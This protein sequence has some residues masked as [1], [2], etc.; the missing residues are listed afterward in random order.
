VRALVDAWVQAQNAGNFAAYSSLY[1]ERFTGIKRVGHRARRYDTR[2]QWLADRKKMFAQPMTV[3]ASLEGMRAN[4]GGMAVRVHQRFASGSFADAGYKVLELVEQ[5]DGALRIT[6][7]EML[8]SLVGAS[9]AAR[10]PAA[11]AFVQRVGT[12][13][14]VLL[15]P[16]PRSFRV[17][18]PVAHGQDFNRYFIAPISE[19]DAPELARW[20]GRDFRLLGEDG[21][22]HADA[23]RP[24]LYVHYTT[25]L[26]DQWSDRWSD[27]EGK[28]ADLGAEEVLRDMRSRPE[29][30]LAFTL[31]LP[32]DSPC[33]ERSRLAHDAQLPPVRAA[34]ATASDPR[35]EAAVLARVVARPTFVELKRQLKSDD[36]D[37]ADTTLDRRVEVTLYGADPPD[38]DT[39]RFAW[40]SLRFDCPCVLCE[41]VWDAA[42]KIT[43][44]HSGDPDVRVLFEEPWQTGDYLHALVDLDGKGE[45]APVVA[46]WGKRCLRH[47]KLTACTSPITD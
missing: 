39:P 31:D 9:D 27:D 42:L 10:D 28:H 25:D 34:F 47:A 45:Y 40:A 15:G 24:Y 8:A 6:R 26:L 3:Q 35:A 19:P 44:T 14:L 17:G 2:A 46:S 1:A 29:V 16:P 30:E 11:F 41:Y 4:A 5:P 33:L 36:P 43:P 21:G 20:H 7:E 12:M 38:S 22:C 18:T 13:L 32:P 37:F 23:L